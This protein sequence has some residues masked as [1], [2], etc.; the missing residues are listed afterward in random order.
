[1]GVLYVLFGCIG[2][3]LI[4]LT[5][6]WVVR[7]MWKEVKENRLS[8]GAWFGM[9]LVFCLCGAAI[10]F[11]SYTLGTNLFPY[12][13]LTGEEVSVTVTSVQHGT[14]L[15]TTGTPES[16][17]HHNVDYTTFTCSEFPGQSFKHPGKSAWEVGQRVKLKVYK[18]DGEV[19]K[20]E[21]IE[22]K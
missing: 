8:A 17:S 4:A 13:F 14:E 12:L 15:F 9:T 5:L 20:H 1:M 22:A 10:S 6:L 11:K 21:V 7:A 2:P 18:I 16:R 19:V 3:L